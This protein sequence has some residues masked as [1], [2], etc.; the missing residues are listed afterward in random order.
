MLPGWE[1]KRLAHWVQ[2][3]CQV[4]ACFDVQR[5]QHAASEAAC[6]PSSAGSLWLP[7]VSQPRSSAVPSTHRASVWRCGR[8]W[9]THMPSDSTPCSSWPRLCPYA[10]QTKWT[11]TV[12]YRFKGG[13]DGRNPSA[14][15]TCD[16]SGAIYGTTFLGGSGKC[17]N[18]FGTLVGCGTVFKLAPPALGLPPT[19]CRRPRRSRQLTGGKLNRHIWGVFS[20]RW[21]SAPAIST[22]RRAT[23]PSMRG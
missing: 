9:L 22:A 7:P 11:E 15:L 4:R 1:V 2:A 20:R 21:I 10:G 23:D 3:R 16:G 8:S 13:T 12:L 17:T 5:G 6:M 19:A 18:K 14:T